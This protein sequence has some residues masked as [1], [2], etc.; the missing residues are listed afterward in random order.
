[1]KEIICINRKQFNLINGNKYHVVSDLEN[2]YIIIDDNGL[3]M[4]YSKQLFKEVKEDIV[5]VIEEPNPMT[6]EEILE[7]VEI[8]YN[9]GNGIEINLTINN[10]NTNILYILSTEDT[11]ISC[12]VYGIYHLQEQLDSICEKIP[13]KK[14][15]QAK[16][17]NKILDWTVN[18][19]LETK[20]AILS[21]NTSY[22]N[23]NV[24]EE[25]V[26]LSNIVSEV[27]GIN[28]NSN[29]EIVL[30]TIEAN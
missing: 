25:A 30:W 1:M 26:K 12:G 27:K 18:E 4:P 17:F 13:N 22:G 16:I 5:E 10:K 6:Y 14:V 9:D 23:F 24:L 19:R 11:Y 15:L 29:N 21:T 8:N 2:H 3:K 20:F 7:S 28:S